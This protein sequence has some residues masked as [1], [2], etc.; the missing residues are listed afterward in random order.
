MIR[1]L[2]AENSVEGNSNKRRPA[3]SNRRRKECEKQELEKRKFERLN[4]KRESGKAETEKR[5]RKT[6]ERKI[7][8]RTMCRYL[9]DSVGILGG[10]SLSKTI[11]CESGSLCPFILTEVIDEFFDHVHDRDTEDV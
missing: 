1:V 9:E 11:K 4:S 7:S 2:T 5:V 3:K 8:R 6:R 10:V